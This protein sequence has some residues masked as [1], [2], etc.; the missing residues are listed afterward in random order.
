VDGAKL[1][2]ERCCSLALLGWPAKASH[3]RASVLW[4]L[5]KW[6]GG[7]MGSVHVF[8]IGTVPPTLELL[9]TSNGR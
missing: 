2:V 9:R 1:D 5:L 8:L 4:L 7:T 6:S 3:L